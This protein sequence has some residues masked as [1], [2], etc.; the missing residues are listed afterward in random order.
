MSPPLGVRQR[1][2]R[3]PSEGLHL[4][5]CKHG[6]EGFLLGQ[7]LSGSARGCPSAK[8]QQGGQGLGGQ[9]FSKTPWGQHP[10]PTGQSGGN[11]SGPH[12][13]AWGQFQIQ[14]QP[15]EDPEEGAQPRVRLKRS[16]DHLMGEAQAR[17]P[18][19]NP[20]GW[21]GRTGERVCHPLSK[22]HLQRLLVSEKLVLDDVLCIRQGKPAGT[23][24]S[25][26]AL[27]TWRPAISHTAWSQ[28][29][30]VTGLLEPLRRS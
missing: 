26:H 13:G 6:E 20:G 18:T 17:R 12:T 8:G 14:I 15:E 24:S 27:S 28:T 19:R 1:E 2:S 7:S 10:S 30:W 21:A 23:S 9:L 29:Q 25:S 22:S 3:D 16:K 11:S 4:V 5:P